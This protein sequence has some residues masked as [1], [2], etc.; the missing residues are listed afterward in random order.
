MPAKHFVTLTCHAD[1]HVETQQWSPLAWCLA[2]HQSCRQ[3]EEWRYSA[4]TTPVDTFSALGNPAQAWRAVYDIGYVPYLFPT[5]TPN[6]HSHR[7]LEITFHHRSVV[8]GLKVAGVS[9]VRGPEGESEWGAVTRFS[10]LY[11]NN[12]GEWDYYA[13]MSGT[14]RVSCY[15][16][17]VWLNAGS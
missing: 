10:L 12:G 13:D 6:H 16:Y 2:Q 4:E 5:D 9:N 8:M 3:P 17:H 14:P 1:E 11:K 7:L 15:L